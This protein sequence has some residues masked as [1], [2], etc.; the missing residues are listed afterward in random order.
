MTVPIVLALRQQYPDLKISILSREF[1]RPFFNEIPEIIFHPIDP[2]Y[3]NS[4]LSGLYKLFRKLSEYDIDAVADLHDVLRT[5]VLKNLFKASRIHNA[6]IDKGRADRKKLVALSKKKLKPIKSIFQRHSDVCSSLGLPI[7]LSNVKLFRQKE[8]SAEVVEITGNKNS[9][10]I[11]IAP[12]ATYKT[13]VYP[14][15]KME[16]VIKGLE[17]KGHQIFLFGG[18]KKETESLDKISSSFKNCVNIA[19]RLSFQHE[20]ELI[21]N[22]DLMVS[23]DS[24]NGHMAALFGVPVITLWGNTHPYAGFVPFGQPLENSITADLN[25]YPFI[26]T[27]IYGNKIIP[28]YEDCMQSIESNT[29]VQKINRLLEAG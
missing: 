28:G 5:K 22:L 16:Q 21:S 9:K 24:G 11:G 8:I 23:M 15:N 27:S 14:L 17:K 13:K 6:S 20:L 3:L 7:D 18:G 4:G 26:P 19:G 1:F 29:I 10:W 2:E 25:Q 12:F